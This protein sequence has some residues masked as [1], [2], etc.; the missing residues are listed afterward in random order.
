VAA[1][2]PLPPAVSAL[3]DVGVGLARR[4]P[5]ARLTIARAG[6]MLP[7]AA[8]SPKMWKAVSREAS[9]ASAAVCV[10]MSAKDVESALKDAWGAAP[11]KVLDDFEAEPVALRPASQVHRGQ[12]DG[13]AVAVKVR[14]P[15]V[16]RSVRNDLSLM[17][18]VAGPLGSA[19]PRLDAGAVLRDIREQVLDEL[20]FE[21]EASTQRRAARA[22]RG[23]GGVHVP[24]PESELCTPA[25]LVAEWVEGTPLSAGASV[26]D[27]EA[28][29]RALAVAVR[30]MVL[31]HGLAPVDLRASHVIVG[32]D[33]EVGLLG[34]GVARPVSRERAASAL[35]A[36]S[37]L[38][39]A[40]ASTFG[41]RV[42]AT[43]VLDAAEAEA[44]YPVLRSVAGWMT[45]GPGVLDAAALREG[46][47]R[48]WSVAPQLSALAVQAAPQPE[49]L[50]LG[51]ALGQ[52]VLV[53]SW[54]G[55]S[56]DWRE[57]VEP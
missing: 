32:A 5:S 8:Y 38:V 1:N 4:A 23:V 45:T 21:H 20:D 52:L 33:D 36:L 10:P 35:E 24:R 29:A 39:S 53:L 31:E 19:F 16:D 25:V 28:V 14:R 15:G 34:T 26:G 13:K 9:A 18:V 57:L 22:V 37:A 17:D 6:E 7:E 40:D 2:T 3:L 30:T 55:A 11:T 43:G 41:A 48:A 49:D 51:R 42:A 44:A 12:F 54:L 56:L 50:A 46:G 47:E 27:P